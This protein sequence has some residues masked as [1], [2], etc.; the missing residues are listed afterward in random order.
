VK[1]G[2]VKGMRFAPLWC[3]AFGLVSGVVGYDFL[4][5]YKLT[6]DYYAGQVKLTK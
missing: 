1:E 5:D 6:L 2:N 4:S 3:V